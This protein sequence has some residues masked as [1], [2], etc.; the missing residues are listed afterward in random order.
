LHRSKLLG[1]GCFLPVF[2]VKLEKV[3][4]FLVTV[5]VTITTKSIIFAIVVV[6]TT[7]QIIIVVVVI[8][9]ASEMA[10]TFFI[11]FQHAHLAPFLGCWSLIKKK[12]E[13]EKR[14]SKIPETSSTLN[15]YMS[16][17]L[18]INRETSSRHHHISPF[19]LRQRRIGI[20]RHF[21]CALGSGALLLS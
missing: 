6:I 21:T 11:H 4:A 15:E 18:S 14:Q 9:A 5:T 16:Q 7:A 13:V 10:A 3:L 1:S 12:I 20:A 17:S 8:F 2:L 19:Y